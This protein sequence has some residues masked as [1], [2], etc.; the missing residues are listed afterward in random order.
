MKNVLNKIC[1]SIIFMLCSLIFVEYGNNRELYKKN[2]LDNNIS[3]TKLR[4]Y[5]DKF[6]VGK[7]EISSDEELLVSNDLDYQFVDGMYKYLKEEVDA[8]ESGIVVFVGDKDDLG[9]TIIVQGVDGVDIWYSNLNQVNVSLYDYINEDDVLGISNEYY[10]VSL[11][12]DGNLITYD[13][14]N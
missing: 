8:V 10:L 3:F 13:E 1:F 2:V 9:K 7:K 5:Y 4:G 6:F 14:Y 12:K 11:Y